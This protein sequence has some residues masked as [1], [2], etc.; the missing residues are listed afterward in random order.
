MNRWISKLGRAGAALLVVAAVLVPAGGASAADEVDGPWYIVSSAAGNRCLDVPAQSGGG[1]GTTLQ[2]WDC[3]PPSQTNQ[4]WWRRWRTSNTFELISAANG[5]CL[6]APAQW[7][8]ADG[9][10]IQLWDCYPP[11]QTNQMWRLM[12]PTVGWRLQSVGYSKVVQAGPG[13]GNQNGT[14]VQSWYLDTGNLNQAWTLKSPNG[15]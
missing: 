13:Q 9:K 8:G 7:G 6:D 14:G 11:S 2:V 1:N 12:A 5:R 3:Y 10:P 4:M 15:F